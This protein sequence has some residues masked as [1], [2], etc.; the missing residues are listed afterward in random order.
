MQTLVSE[1]LQFDKITKSDYPEFQSWYSNEQI[2]KFITGRSL[3]PNEILKKFRKVIDENLQEQHLGWWSVRLQSTGEFIGIAK[4]V[5]ED[6]TCIEI[7]YG[8]LPEYWGQGYTT[9]MVSALILYASEIPQVEELVAM[10]DSQNTASVKILTRFKFAPRDS[11]SKQMTYF[12]KMK[13]D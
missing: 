12:L 8:L 10:V 4:L 9:E 11:D 13:E 6:K 3:S 2:M 7:G 5:R 1:R